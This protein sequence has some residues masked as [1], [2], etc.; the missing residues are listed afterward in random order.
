M[1]HRSTPREQLWPPIAKRKRMAAERK[2]QAARQLRYEAD[3]LDR[4]WADF[5]AKQTDA[6]AAA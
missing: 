2:E 5:C 6:E 1:P 4:K 3:E